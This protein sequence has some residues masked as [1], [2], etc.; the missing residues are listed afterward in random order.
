VCGKASCA[1]NVKK[2]SPKRKFF[3]SSYF[4]LAFWCDENESEP[5]DEW[6]P[7]ELSLSL[8]QKKRKERNKRKTKKKR[9]NNNN[10]NASAAAARSCVSFSR[11]MSLRNR[12]NTQQRHINVLTN[13]KRRTKKS[14][15]RHKISFS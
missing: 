11:A 5:S 3:L 13:H 7:G 4:Q 15:S 8:Y 6:F 14:T 10:N 12:L 1:V 9:E 2:Y